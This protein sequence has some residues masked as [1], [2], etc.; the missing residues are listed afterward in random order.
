MERFVLV[1]GLLVHDPAQRHPGRGA[2]ACDRACAEH[3]LVAGGFQ[4]SFRQAV[5]VNADLLHSD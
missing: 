4:R 3:A 5:A 2:Y 1:D